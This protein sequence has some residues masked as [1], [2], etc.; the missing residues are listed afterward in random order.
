MWRLANSVIQEDPQ[1]FGVFNT[2]LN[3]IIRKALY[4]PTPK[5]LA[6]ARSK[7]RVPVKSKPKSKKK[8]MGKKKGK[9][10]GKTNKKTT[11]SASSKEDFS[12]GKAPSGR[13]RC[14]SNGRIAN[15]RIR[16]NGSFRMYVELENGSAVGM[17]DDKR[18]LIQSVKGAALNFTE[19]FKSFQVSKRGYALV[20]NGKTRC[21]LRN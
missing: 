10:K 21:D 6:K 7:P 8:S 15:L 9:T 16:K 17:C 1:S 11:T 20:L 5:Q 13:Y 3:G 2:A 14:I 4:K 18:C 12:A 19:G